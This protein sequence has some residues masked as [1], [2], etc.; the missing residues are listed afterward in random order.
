MKKVFLAMFAA[1]LVCGMTAVKAQDFYD[2]SAVSSSGDTLYYY[3][4]NGVAVVTCPGDIDEEDYWPEG[5]SQ[6]QGALVIDGTVTHND[7]TYSV[8]RIGAYAFYGCSDITSVNI[9]G[10]VNIIKGYAFYD[11]GNMASVTIPASV[12]DFGNYVFT[13]TALPDPIYKDSVFVYMPAT[14]TG[15]YTIPNQITK[16]SGGAFYHCANL[17]QV[18]LPNSVTWIG[19]GAFLE[20]NGLTQPI[21]NNTLFARLPVSYSGSYTIPDGITTVCAS[22]FTYTS[23]LTELIM[24]NSVTSMGNG[25]LG[26]CTSLTSVALSNA[27]TEIPGF[28][29]MGCTALSTITL[30]AGI[31][32]IGAAAF[33]NC[34]AMDSIV[35]KSTTPPSAGM[36]AFRNLPASCRL[37]VTCGTLEAYTEAWGTYFTQIVEDCGSGEGI[38]DL[39]STQVRVY[40]TDGC[41]VIAPEDGS[42]AITANVYDMSGRLVASLPTAGKTPALPNGIYVVSIG[43]QSVRKVVVRR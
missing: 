25:A 41:I 34:T 28:T 35:V 29:F 31:H 24:P 40:V 4:D 11:C 33:F 18:V 37:V 22:A 5:V 32:N 23:G 17:S 26:S 6:P 20:C 13:G 39:E 27:L 30:P 8:A 2:F 36:S 38:N 7:T 14:A 3:L 1:I 21:Y 42:E 16:I 43:N 12:A 9:P 15:T 10:S 19:P